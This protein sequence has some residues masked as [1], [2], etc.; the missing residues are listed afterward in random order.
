MAERLI[1]HYHDRDTAL[2]RVDARI[3]LFSLLLITIV[4]FN[5]PDVVIF[6]IIILL[7]AAG[8]AGRIPLPEYRRELAFFFVFGS[9]IF[10]TRWLSNGL[11]SEALY[12]ALRFL[13]VVAGGLLLTDS[14]SPEEISLS[15]FWIISPFSRKRAYEFSA[16][17]SLTISFI[18]MLFDASSQISEARKARRDRRFRRP[19]RRIISMASQLMDQIIDRAEEI[20]YALE[21]R[22][23][24][25]YVLHDSLGWRTAD[26]LILI[27]IIIYLAVTS[28]LVVIM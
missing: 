6:P 7:S 23:F 2:N 16:A 22:R 25:P 13:T 8:I 14:T 21:S 27:G 17:F 19:L 24:T 10:L 26:S 20:S 4:V 9:L 3:K 1:F 15:V 12:A 11:F 5:S 28:F 18:P